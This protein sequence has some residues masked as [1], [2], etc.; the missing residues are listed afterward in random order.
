MASGRSIRVRISGLVAVPALALVAVTGYVAAD[1]AGEAS[2]LRAAATA[3]AVLGD[4]AGGLIVALQREHLVTAE[5]LATRSDRGRTALIQQRARTD[6]ARTHLRDRSAAP[7]TRAAMTA[8]VKAAHDALMRE[9]RRVDALRASIDETREATGG[10]DGGTKTRGRGDK[11]RPKAPAT[12]ADTTTATGTTRPVPTATTR[13]VPTGTTRPVATDTSRPA[14]T[15]TTRPVPT[16]TTRP[17]ATGTTRPVATDTSRPAATDTATTR[18]TAHA[19]ARGEERADGSGTQVA[20]ADDGRAGGSG[21]R[22]AARGE[23]RAG[24]SAVR[25]VT[26]AEGIALAALAPEFGRVTEAGQRLVTAVMMSTDPALYRQARALATLAQAKDLLAGERALA[27]GVLA[28]GRQMTPAEQR[29]FGR[30]AGTRAYLYEQ[31]V[32]E[33]E[34]ALRAPF[35]RAGA[36]EAY[37]RFAAAEDRLAAGNALRVSH[38]EWRTFGDQVDAAYQKA[39][40]ESGKALAARIGPLADEALLRAGLAA[41]TGLAALLISVLV[42]RRVGRGVVREL[43]VLRTA[44]REL[45]AV[46]LPAVTARVR[47]GEEVDLTTAVPSFVSPRHSREVRELAHALDGLRR[48]AV[49]AA[50]ERAVLRASA[51]QALRGVAKRSQSMLQRQLRMLDVMQR[52]T[53]DARALENLV[54]IDHHTTRMRRYAESLIVL[55]GG[56]PGRSWRRPVPVAHALRAAVAGI[57]EYGR[58]RVYPMPE[59]RIAGPAVAD[60]VHV[61]GELIDNAVAY[62]PDNTEVSVRG[63]AAGDAYRI[64][65]EDRGGGMALGE[66]KAANRM[67]AGPPEELDLAGIDRLGL[68][69]AG[70]L[71][72]KHGLRVELAAS[73]FGG[74]TAVVLIPGSLVT[75]P[76][77]APP[78]ETGDEERTGER[79]DARPG[80][81][82]GEA[83]AAEEAGGA[84]EL[85]GGQ[86]VGGQVAG[87]Q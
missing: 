48:T 11:T 53:K 32:A 65:V 87:D 57:E 9:S 68:L 24:G 50:A 22:R 63:E 49:E 26:G 18:P 8:E 43:G 35:Q 54:R 28:A 25:R 16:G 12:T 13:P 44:A 21:V 70:R 20:A 1:A 80:R 10:T 19:A 72:V 41:A 74:T 56:S 69:V 36:G 75:L 29:A 77:A 27:A 58:V 61:L 62:S 78:A 47:Q 3:H 38:P 81:R 17:A 83:A 23:E 6:R 14:A 73:P 64:E 46:R 39:L 34:P 37:R 59:A 84:G 31:G 76:P 51:G 15:D 71:A 66:R 5:Y 82:P 55:S 60:V 33:L 86:K 42:A 67:L 45:T 40:D 52:R 4:A 85:V 2:R 30:L 79:P 7:E